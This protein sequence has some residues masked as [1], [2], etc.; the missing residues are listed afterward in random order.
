[1]SSHGEYT[2][3]YIRFVARGS[4]PALP[5]ATSVNPVDGAVLVSRIVAVVRTVPVSAVHRALVG[6]AASEVVVE[7]VGSGVVGDDGE[8]VGRRL[9]KRTRDA[10]GLEGRFFVGVRRPHG[11]AALG[12]RGTKRLGEHSR[13]GEVS[14]EDPLEKSRRRLRR[15]RVGQPRVRCGVLAAQQE[16]RRVACVEGHADRRQLHGA[17]DAQEPSDGDDVHHDH[18]VDLAPAALGIQLA[19]GLRDAWQVGSH[20]DVR[21]EVHGDGPTVASGAEAA[22][23]AEVVGWPVQVPPSAPP[24]RRCSRCG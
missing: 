14:A 6:D 17:G 13:T 9:R 3:R 1:M 15:D 4:P 5:A 10:E 20:R 7:L 11:H 21:P 16:L 24:V 19:D 8:T 18:A 12:H 2:D 22:V 23:P